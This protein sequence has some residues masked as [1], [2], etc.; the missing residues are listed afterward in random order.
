MYQS[1]SPQLQGSVPLS[2]NSSHSSTSTSLFLTPSCSVLLK[3][4]L[5]DLF[6]T[7]RRANLIKERQARRQC[8]HLFAGAL[9]LLGAGGGEPQLEVPNRS[10]KAALKEIFTGTISLKSLIHAQNKFLS[11]PL[12]LPTNSVFHT[13]LVSAPYFLV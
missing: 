3:S 13:D 7:K 2:T 6:C 10:R 9:R 1:F 12:F 5:F 4:L 8:L 11:F